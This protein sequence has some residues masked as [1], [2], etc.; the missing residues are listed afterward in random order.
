MQLVHLAREAQP[1]GQTT[2]LA[3]GFVAAA[4]T[5]YLAIR[6]L[7]RHLQRHSLYPFAIYCWVAGAVS[8]IA[9]LTHIV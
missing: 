9:A 2:L 1:A 7:L 4:V 3:I 6:F 5:G 8:L